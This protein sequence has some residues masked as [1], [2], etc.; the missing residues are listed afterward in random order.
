MYIDVYVGCMYLYIR[1]ALCVIY[2]IFS[3]F[4][5]SC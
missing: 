4:G 3:L 2:Y 5:G 1:L